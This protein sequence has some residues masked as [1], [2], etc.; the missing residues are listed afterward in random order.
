MSDRQDLSGSYCIG[1]QSNAVSIQ[2]QGSNTSDVEAG[3]APFVRITM[4]SN[5]SGNTSFKLRSSWIRGNSIIVPWISNT[6]TSGGFPLVVNVSNVQDGNCQI[7]VSAIAN[8]SLSPP[9]VFIWI[10]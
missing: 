6:L 10:L 1:L 2:Q 5:V 4:F 7:T 8:E 9:I 3:N